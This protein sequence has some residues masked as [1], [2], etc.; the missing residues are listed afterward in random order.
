MEI[1]VQYQLPFFFCLFHQQLSVVNCRVQ[2]P[3]RLQPLSIQVCACQ[4]APIVSNDNPIDIQHRDYFEHKIIPQYF[5]QHTVSKEEINN[6]LNNLTYHCLSR[7]HSGGYY[8]SFFIFQVCTILPNYKIV[9]RISRLTQ[10]QL[11][12]L[13]FTLFAGIVLERFQIPA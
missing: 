5:C 7:V 2:F 4:I 13:K 1:N 6:I 8:D 12:S 3:W 9:A 10:K 11:L